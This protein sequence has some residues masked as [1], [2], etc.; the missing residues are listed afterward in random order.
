MKFILGVLLLCS[1]NL[2]F[3]TFH[4]NDNKAI[5]ITLKEITKNINK[6]S[7][8]PSPHLFK[9]RTNSKMAKRLLNSKYFSKNKIRRT[10]KREFGKYTDKKLLNLTKC[11]GKRVQ[12]HTVW[13]F[14]KINENLNGSLN[15]AKRKRINK[16]LKDLDKGLSLI[17]KL[18]KVQEFDIKL[19][20]R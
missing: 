20:K 10:L 8:K 11:Y 16:Y 5:N 1:F 13:I 19:G 6:C 18:K 17:A 12:Q 2:C 9:L 15:S 4:V 7:Q 3:A 14:R